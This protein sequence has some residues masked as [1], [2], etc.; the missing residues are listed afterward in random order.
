MTQY[1]HQETEPRPIYVYDTSEVYGEKG[2]FRVLEFGNDAIQGIL[3]LNQPER[4]LFE[5]PR[6][7]LH[8]MEVNNP[9]YEDVFLIGHGI[10]TLSSALRDK[11]VVISEIDQKV[12]DVSKEYF[13]YNGPPVLIEDG[14]TLLKEMTSG[15]FDY[16]VVDAFH[17]GGIPEQLTTMDFFETACDKLTEDGT[18]LMN[19]IGRGP[20]DPYVQSFYR[21]LSSL[22]PVV[23]LFSLYA[24]GLGR[25]KN[26]I[27]AAGYHPLRYQKKSMAHFRKITSNILTIGID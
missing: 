27:I 19:I 14:Y 5:Y 25:S 21:S 26:M 11:Y 12:S 22:F 20:Q 4:I 9:S 17:E 1:L 10:G 3:D 18:L 13:G 8:L 2:R 7:I 23:D 24:G 6:A 15:R 16:I